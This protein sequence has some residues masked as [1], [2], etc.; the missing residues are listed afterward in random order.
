MDIDIHAM[1]LIS[2]FIKGN[3]VALID[4]IVVDVVAVDLVSSGN[5]L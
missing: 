3:K 2:I 5:G 4:K 1:R